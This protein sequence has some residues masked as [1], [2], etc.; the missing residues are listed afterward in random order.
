MGQGKVFILQPFHI[1]QHLRLAVIP[2][3]DGMSQIL[4]G[5]LNRFWNR[6]PIVDLSI[7]LNHI[8]RN[9]KNR[10]QRLDIFNSRRFI[11]TDPD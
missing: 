11:Q 2:I 9:T 7:E 8:S 3:K 10:K 4:T 5:P 1:A 6:E